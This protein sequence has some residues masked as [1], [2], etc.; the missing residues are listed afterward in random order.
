MK[1]DT[2]IVYYTENR[3]QALLLL[4]MNRKVQ[5]CNYLYLRKLIKSPKN[6]KKPNKLHTKAKP[7]RISLFDLND[8]NDT[9]QLSVEGEN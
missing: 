5:I 2:K 7:N 8:S 9:K 6:S 1:T 4:Q 3:L